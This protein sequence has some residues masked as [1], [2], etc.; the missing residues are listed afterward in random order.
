MHQFMN[1]NNLTVPYMR[2][3]TLPI[4]ATIN[5]S[6]GST[7]STLKFKSA[8]VQTEGEKLGP[9]TAFMTAT[10]FSTTVG[11]AALSIRPK[12]TFKNRTN[13]S[14]MVIDYI[15]ISNSS[16]TTNADI[17]VS[18]GQNPIGATWQDVNTNFSAFEFSQSNFVCDDATG[19]TI[20]IIALPENA[21]TRINPDYFY[22]ISLSRG[23][24]SRNLGMITIY[25][26]GGS[27]QTTIKWKEYR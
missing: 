20:A 16:P 21:Y 2:T 15:E 7:G 25:S 22:P 23:G 5:G 3:A 27:F 26:E 4:Q 1:A 11:R 17:Y 8:C 9:P 12:L 18:I 14:V 13:R 6:V 10:G 24:E 19:I